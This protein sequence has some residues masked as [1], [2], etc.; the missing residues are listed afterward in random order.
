M[1][2]DGRYNAHNMCVRHA[3]MPA[4]TYAVQVLLCQMFKYILQMKIWSILHQI[5]NVLLIRPGKIVAYTHV[6]NPDISITRSV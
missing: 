1:L 3:E 5:V 4:V 6:H 2:A